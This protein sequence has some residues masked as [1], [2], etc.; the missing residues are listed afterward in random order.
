MNLSVLWAD[1]PWY[2]GTYVFCWWCVKTWF[3]TS[4]G[5]RLWGTWLCTMPDV[6][7]YGLGCVLMPLWGKNWKL[8]ELR[9]W[10]L[11]LIRTGLGTMVVP[12]GSVVVVVILRNYL[13]VVIGTWYILDDFYWLVCDD[14]W[15]ELAKINSKI[16]DNFLSL[17]PI[18]HS[19]SRMQFSFILPV[20]N[21]CVDKMDYL[22]RECA[23]TGVTAVTIWV[24]VTNPLSGN[25]VCIKCLETSQ[26][27]NLHYWKY[28]GF[29]VWCKMSFSFKRM[30]N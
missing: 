2:F 10:G 15:L 7:F 1:E 28:K 24:G 19:A 21:V 11:V 22:F 3:L 9:L 13:G 18:W 27:V 26:L 16:K 8:G 20:R 6:A 17:H 4:L 12:V 5:Y 30:Q 23:V 14:I 29:G 25:M